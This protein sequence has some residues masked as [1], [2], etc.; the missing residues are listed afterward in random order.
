MPIFQYR[1]YRTD[2]FEVAGTIEANS[3]KDAVL[4]L[5]DLGL[6]PKNVKEVAYRRIP[7]IFQGSNVSRLP[8]VTRQLAILLSSGATLMESLKSLSEENKGFWRNVLIDIKEKVA[9]G[10]SFSKAID[11]YKDIFPEYYVNMVAAGE[12]SGN[13]DKVLGQLSDF[14]EGQDELKA[15]VR[16]SMIYPVFMICVSFIVLSFLFTFVIPRITRIFEDTQSALPLITLVLITISNFFQHYWWLIIGVLLVGMFG[17]K[18]LKEKKGEFIDRLILHLPGN[19]P[20]SLYFARFT[21]VLSFLLEGGLPLLRS[22]ELSAK[23]IG[24]K[25][26]ERKAIEAGEKVAEGVRLSTAMEGFPPVLLQLI[27]TGER[28]GKL[29]E[30]LKNAAHSYEEE[31]SRRVQKSLS[32]L[33]PSM[34]LLMGLIVGFIVLAVLLPIFQLNQLIRIR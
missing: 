6:Y 14:L 29:I 10:S 27:S 7:R 30:V 15:K 5:K 20:Q 9:E 33:E 16:M 26:V 25:V 4:R 8:A 32:L 23:S 34:I 21:R 12:T 19:I 3:L 18:K 11:R 17:F 13:L 1:G 28:S 31:F 2:G 22:L 24:N